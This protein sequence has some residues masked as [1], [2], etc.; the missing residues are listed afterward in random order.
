M[1]YKSLTLDD[2]FTDYD[3]KHS[4]LN[5]SCMKQG[6]NGIQKYSCIT[7]YL[8]DDIMRHK[9]KRNILDNLKV[10]HYIKIGDECPICYEQI[11]NRKKAF[12]TDCGHS[13]HYKCIIDYDYKNIFT[14]NGVY[15][16]LCR[17]DMGYYDDMKDRYKDSN[18][19]FD[20]LDDFELNM[21]LKFPKMCYNLNSLNSNKHFHRTQYFTCIH[22]R[23]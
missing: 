23:I 7:I 20:K 4:H 10:K 19:I 11:C 1:S 15:C 2:I 17:D 8:T 14:K 13:F 18:N 16:P 5:V 3:N 12:L 9:I 22:C 21:K 6:I